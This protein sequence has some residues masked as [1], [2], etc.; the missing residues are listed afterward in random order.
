MANSFNT[1]SD[2]L[3][4]KCLVTRDF[5]ELGRVFE[6][7]VVTAIKPAAFYKARNLDR[8]TL[9]NVTHV[10]QHAFGGCSIGNISLGWTGIES[11]EHNAF[12]LCLVNVGLPSS[13]TLSAL[14][15][16]DSGAFAGNSS[17]PNTWLQSIS[18]PLWTGTTTG[19]SRIGND[20]LGIFEYCTALTS[21]SLP[22]LKSVPANM[23]KNA[24]A[25]QEIVLPKCTSLGSTSFANCAAL[26]KLDIG[27]DMTSMTTAFISGSTA[28]DAII[29]RGLTT[30]P[31]TNTNTLNFTSL[32]NGTTFFYVPKSLE[33][34][35]KVASVWQD[36]SSQIRAIEDY[37]AICGS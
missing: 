14:T 33:A 36:H 30:V 1:Y 32:N 29:L 35:F 3:I 18:L 24:S 27:G 19:A 11:I 34:T 20:N 2:K 9:P 10:G 28:P 37:P 22:E 15:A 26:K 8:V 5:G 7:N 13:L 16:L 25:I 17:V 21:V 4:L 12:A 23:F 31:R 6:D